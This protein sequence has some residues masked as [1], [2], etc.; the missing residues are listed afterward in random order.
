[1]NVG[2]SQLNILLG[3]NNARLYDLEPRSK[4]NFDC[5]MIRQTP[6]QHWHWWHGLTAAGLQ[7]GLENYGVRAVG[8]ASYLV[9]SARRYAMVAV[10][11]GNAIEAEVGNGMRSVTNGTVDFTLKEGA[12]LGLPRTTIQSFMSNCQLAYKGGACDFVPS[13]GT[14]T[15]HRAEFGRLSLPWLSNGV[16]TPRQ[17]AFGAFVNDASNA[18]GA[19]NAIWTKGIPVMLRNLIHNAMATWSGSLASTIVIGSGCGTPNYSHVTHTLPRLGVNVAYRGNSGLPS[20][21]APLAFGFS[22]TNWSGLPLPLS[23]QPFGSSPGCFA[24]NDWAVTFGCT[25]NT[26]GFSQH[27]LSIP[28]DFGLVGYQ[29][30]SPWYSLNGT[31]SISSNGLRPQIGQ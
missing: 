29:F 19:E 11:N 13:V 8:V 10:G 31:T 1:M 15:D 27:V 17:I 2:Q 18:A 24:Y 23:L 14:P 6:S 28:N 3:T 21:T 4:G 16:L 30:Y 9:G 7:D 20:A 12:A 5:V 22:D 25:T 26:A